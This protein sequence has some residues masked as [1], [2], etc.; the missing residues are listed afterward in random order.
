M[1]LWQNGDAP[2]FDTGQCRFKSCRGLR[3]GRYMDEEKNQPTALGSGLCVTP[4]P[5]TGKTFGD[6]EKPKLVKILNYGHPK[7]REVAN[8]V[9][10][11]SPFDD[12][13]IDDMMK[14]VASFPALGI[15]ATQLGRNVRIIIVN[16]IAEIIP[17]INPKIVEFSQEESSIAEGCMSILGAT[18]DV[19]RSDRVVVEGLDAD[20]R[21][22]RYEWSGMIAHIAQHE[23]DH[24]DGV[25]M[26]DHLR[27]YK[28]N[29]ML[30]K[31]R[32]FIRDKR[33]P[34]HSYQIALK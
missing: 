15:A 26:V 27:E 5:K 1:S 22:V 13:L 17:I 29:K 30:K 19:E 34:V 21:E 31:H 18:E 2:V 8:E 23:I 3:K 7:L 32:K 24:L 16:T 10:E 28:R 33:M 25:M 4:K 6:V 9:T 20:M 14:A 12:I 11:L